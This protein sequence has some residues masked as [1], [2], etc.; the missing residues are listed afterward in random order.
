M[1]GSIA[2]ATAGGTA[3]SSVTKFAAHEKAHITLDL[4]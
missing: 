2:V 4:G 1:F 3:G